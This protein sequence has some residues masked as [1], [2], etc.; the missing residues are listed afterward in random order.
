MNRPSTE[1][2][3]AALKSATRLLLSDVGGLDA[4]AAA[5]R[6]QRSQLSDYT[7]RHLEKFLPVDI[8]LDL[9][10]AADTPHVTAALA[11]AQGYQLVRI[12]GRH[13]HALARELARIGAD[14]ARLLALA[15]DALAGSPLAD[16]TRA[17]MIADLDDLARACI[18]SMALLRASPED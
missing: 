16:T 4:S 7:A 5:T 10:R 6:V 3:R 15:A 11:R 13:P 12:D 8:A 18:D 1:I 17:E 14:T 2:E 9:E